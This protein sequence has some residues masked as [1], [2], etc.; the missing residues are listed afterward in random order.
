MIP[1]RK[2]WR[3]NGNTIH[4]YWHFSKSWS[5]IQKF[6]V[7][8]SKFGVNEASAVAA[9]KSIFFLVDWLSSGEHHANKSV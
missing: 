1:F 3:L 8:N 4:F 6:G 5:Q 2:I 9:I 7:R